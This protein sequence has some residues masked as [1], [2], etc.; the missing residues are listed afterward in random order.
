MSIVI[1]TNAS[2]GTDVVIG[3]MG[4][5]VENS[6]G[7]ITLI[8]KHDIE[9]ARD[10]DDLVTLATDD[11]HGAGSSTLILNDGAS[12]V[13]QSDVENFL[14]ARLPT[15]PAGGD[16]SGGFPDPVASRASSSFA[17][18]GEISPASFST[19]QDDYN[20]T[21]LSTASVLRLTATAAASITGLTGGAAGRLIEIHNI[22][23]FNITL[24][25]EDASSTAANRFLN[26][27]VLPPSRDVL[28]RYDGNVSRWRVFATS[29]LSGVHT[30]I[31]SEISAITQKTSPVPAD[32]ILIEDSED[33]NNKK[34]VS[35][36]Q[37]G[38]AVINPQL[39]ASGTGIITTTSLSD[40]LI[41]GLT[42]TPGAGT[43]VAL[44]SMTASHNKSG[45][46]IFGSIW[47][48]GAQIAYTERDIG[49]QSNNLGNL[50]A[51]AIATVAD[52]EAIEARWRVSSNAGGGTG[53]SPGPRVL[54][55]LRIS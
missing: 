19:Q 4:M 18:T 39:V 23:S 17:M 40:V 34:Y 15:G 6:G 24:S 41:T 46:T 12:D 20:P 29:D 48:A 42:L 22:G 50:A 31:A 38:G 11:A 52:A 7:T 5:L 2:Q 27:C 32:L 26:S 9:K 21:G 10:S 45:Q 16:L 36:S 1:R 51:Q 55:L 37:L 28:L 47:A 35:L 49:G 25:G 13:A 54:I 30:N 43:Y 53:S 44:F 14:I 33:S 3:D 8:S